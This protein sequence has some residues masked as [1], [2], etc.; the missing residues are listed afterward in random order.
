MRG[1]LGPIVLMD[2]GSLRRRL[3]SM[4]TSGVASSDSAVTPSSSWYT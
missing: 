1:I 2:R 4:M 3:H